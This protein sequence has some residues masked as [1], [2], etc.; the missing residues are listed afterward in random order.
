M[1]T[2]G[3]AIPADVAGYLDRSRKRNPLTTRI[4]ESSVRHAE[5]QKNFCDL[6]ILLRVQAPSKPL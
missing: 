4:Y 6:K 2:H 1:R 5:N 3:A